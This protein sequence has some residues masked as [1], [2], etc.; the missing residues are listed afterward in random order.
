MLVWSPN[1]CV[2]DA[3]REWVGPPGS[4]TSLGAGGFASCQP[5]ASSSQK[6]LGAEV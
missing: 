2:S 1:H 5:G 3:K 6:G 4:R